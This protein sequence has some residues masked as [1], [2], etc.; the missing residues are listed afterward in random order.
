MR[1]CR[2]YR[3]LLRSLICARDVPESASM[4][5]TTAIARKVALV[6]GAA[7]GLG[8]ACAER[9][10]KDGFDIAVTEL[11]AAD[12]AMTCQASVAHGARAQAITLDVR[13]IEAIDACIAATLDNFGR[14]DVL[15]NNAGIPLTK[16]ALEVEPDEFDQVQA[17]NVRGAYFMAQR[18]ARQLVA[19][20]ARGAIVNVASTFAVIGVPGASAYGTSKSAV[21]GMTRH[22]AAEWAH[23]GIRVNA[24][25]PGAVETRLRAAHF[26][27]NPAWREWN[28]A[29][30]PAARFGTPDDT[31]AAVAYLASDA[32]DY[33]NGHLLVVDGALTVT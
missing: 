17:I 3:H 30:V 15:V 8:A 7:Y 31:A 20:E 24:V 19:R 11:D 1:Q 6:T 4:T 16:P 5:S 13:N 27:A 2:T 28:L 10:A 21:A 32:A 22:L 23:Y 18:F 29:R 25:A 33:V 12:L 14:I 9:L 26:A